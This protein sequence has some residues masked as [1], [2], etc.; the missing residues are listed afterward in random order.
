MFHLLEK[1]LSLSFRDT[2]GTRE[3]SKQKKTNQKGKKIQGKKPNPSLSG[4]KSVA[5]ARNNCA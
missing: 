1:R 4:A 2:R 5:G 3:T